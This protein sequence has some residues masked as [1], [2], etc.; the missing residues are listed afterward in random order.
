[1]SLSVGSLVHS[2]WPRR[3]KP[4]YPIG[5]IVSPGPVLADD[6]YSSG[7]DRWVIL[8]SSGRISAHLSQGLKAVE[9]VIT[10]I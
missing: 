7:R 8:W 4:W 2:V 6:I 3:S 1:M 9:E 5:I 10:C